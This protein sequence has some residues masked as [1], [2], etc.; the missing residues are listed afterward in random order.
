M[1][2]A[3]GAGVRQSIFSMVAHVAKNKLRGQYL[4][5]QTGTLI[6]SITA[7]PSVEISRERVA[8]SFG[9]NLGYARMHEEGFKG[10]LQV[11]AHIRRL[12]PRLKPASIRRQL[13][14]GV[15]YFGRLVEAGATLRRTYAIQKRYAHVRAH[16][17]RVDI[18]ARH[19]LLDTLTE[20]TG[21]TNLNVRK[22]LMF[23]ARTGKVPTV[24]DVQSAPLL[25]VFDVRRF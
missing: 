20:K 16:S 25:T 1:H 23:L 5:R 22:A 11:R 24:K 13:H 14:Y 10:R 15:N 17:R 7:S 12:T 4:R 3:L 6:R 18:R 2:R 21:E 19:F 9:S 8:G